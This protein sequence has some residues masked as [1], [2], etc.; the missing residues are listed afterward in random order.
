MAAAGMAHGISVLALCFLASLRWEYPPISPNSKQRGQKAIASQSLQRGLHT[1]GDLGPP[2]WLSSG[3]IKGPT[4]DPCCSRTQRA[5]MG[6][7]SVAHG[8]GREWTDALVLWH[9]HGFSQHDGLDADSSCCWSQG[10]FLTSSMGN[11]LP[12]SQCQGSLDV[13]QQDI[14]RI[15]GPC[16]PWLAFHCRS[17]CLL[18]LQHREVCSWPSG[19]NRSW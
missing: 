10:L 18:P 16:L 12:G 7:L 6:G 1:G 14:V 11:H 8:T 5:W 15:V 9:S 17:G 19:K 3:A 4:L 2:V 13:P